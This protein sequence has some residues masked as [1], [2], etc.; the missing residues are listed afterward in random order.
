MPKKRNKELDFVFDNMALSAGVVGGTHI[1]GKMSSTMPSPQSGA[2]MKG[3]ET[4]KIV[5]IMHATGGIFGQLQGLEKKVKKK[6]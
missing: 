2:I 6:R 4:M 1:V 5:P 3:M